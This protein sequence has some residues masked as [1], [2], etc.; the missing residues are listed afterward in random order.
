MSGKGWARWGV[1]CLVVGG[2]LFSVSTSGARSP[3]RV[4][5]KKQTTPRCPPTRHARLA[6]STRTT[7]IFGVTAA[8]WD[9][10]FACLRP[11]GKSVLLGLQDRSSGE[12]G[13]SSTTGDFTT[14]GP[15][16]AAY[17]TTGEA[18]SVECGKYSSSVLSD[19]CPLPGALIKVVNVRSLR[20]ATVPLGLGWRPLIDDWSLGSLAISS[21]GDLAWLVVDNSGTDHLW[22]STLVPNGNSFSAATMIDTGNI[23]GS[24]LRFINANT[25]EWASNGV[26]YQQAIV[27][28][29]APASC[30]SPPPGYTVVASDPE[31]IVT[32]H[33]VQQ[34]GNP[35]VGWYACWVGVGRQQLLNSAVA[36]GYPGYSTSLQQVVVAGTFVGLVFGYRDTNYCYS[37][38]EID[39][40][41][42]PSA[43]AIRR[44]LTTGTCVS[45]TAPGIDSL[46]L[47]S[48]GLA[49]WREPHLYAYGG[50]LDT[51]TLLA[52]DSQGLQLVDGS[53]SSPVNSITNVALSGN[54][55]TWSDDGTPHQETLH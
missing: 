50:Q 23:D 6:L 36:P 11:H 5:H 13:Y 29:G 12:Y 3:A 25:L 9:R 48:R 10:Y 32:S 46:V 42:D 55:L 18:E 52:Y 17:V 15:F 14:A 38:L 8:G 47:N 30:A 41:A 28:Q 24:S 21:S 54:V 34:Y 33:D 49:A 31:V 35:W 40:L 22:V 53:P 44:L 2:M 51:P 39:N 45:P 26:S 4:A 16:A 1:C 37:Y 20:S 7:A 19:A 43:T 27:P